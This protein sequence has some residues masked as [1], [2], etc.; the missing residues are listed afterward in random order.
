MSASTMRAISK[1]VSL[2]PKTLSKQML[3]VYI[4]ITDNSVHRRRKL[5]SSYASYDGASCIKTVEARKNTEISFAE[6][7]S[8]KLCYYC[9]RIPENTAIAGPMLTIFLRI[10]NDLKKLDK[11]RNDL[12]EPSAVKV[13]N[14][15]K[16]L[17]KDIKDLESITNRY[18]ANP[19]VLPWSEEELRSLSSYT[20]KLETAIFESKRLFSP[21]AALSRIKAS[22]RPHDSDTFIF[23]ESP[24]ACVVN[25]YHSDRTT[26][27]ALL[28]DSSTLK[29]I[30][31]YHLMVLPRFAV[32]FLYAKDLPLSSVSV[33]GLDDEIINTLLSLWSPQI[34][35]PL[36]SLVAVCQT[37][38]ALK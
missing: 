34:S 20:K 13:S 36:N 8:S 35:H 31:E 6:L 9:F 10:D 27:A 2:A 11:L 12:V 23:D 33:E 5:G 30:D 25:K 37:T 17:Q 4:D 22:L 14:L 1:F 24:T 7:A 18:F 32:D 19:E 16:C 28:I 15:Q 26:G 21:K 3:A 29:T 38:L